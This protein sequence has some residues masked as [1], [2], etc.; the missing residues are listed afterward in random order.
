MPRNARSHSRIGAAAIGLLLALTGAA[1]AGSSA[2]LNGLNG[3]S[4]AIQPGGAAPYFP[5]GGPYGI[6]NWQRGNTGQLNPTICAISPC[7]SGGSAAGRSTGRH[8]W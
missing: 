4:V 5:V 1:S 8:P 6:H 7:R 3:G 2:G